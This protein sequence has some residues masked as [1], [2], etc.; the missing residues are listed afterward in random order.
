MDNWQGDTNAWEDESDATWEA[1][2]VLRL[3]FIFVNWL[4]AFINYG[5]TFRG[6]TMNTFLCSLDKEEIQTFPSHAQNYLHYYCVFNNA[7]CISVHLE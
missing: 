3:Y 2:E 4:F 7:G 1:E 6:L 5:K